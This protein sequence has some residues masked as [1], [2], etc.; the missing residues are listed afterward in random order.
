M[1]LEAV[2]ALANSPKRTHMAPN[3]A[4]GS[5]RG[6]GWDP[7]ASAHELLGGRT[8]NGML[9]AASKT[10]GLVIQVTPSPIARLACGRKF[11]TNPPVECPRVI[12]SAMPG[13]NMVRPRLSTTSPAH[14]HQVAA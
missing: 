12:L 10:T 2:S 11:A 3:A 5:H 13:E 8:S 6:P 7:V 9:N 4:S 1:E 14:N